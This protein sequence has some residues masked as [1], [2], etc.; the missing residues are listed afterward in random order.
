MYFRRQSVT[1]L[2][3]NYSALTNYS[4]GPTPLFSEVLLSEANARVHMLDTGHQKYIWFSRQTIRGY[5]FVESSIYLCMWLIY[6]GL[7]EVK[8][9]S[10]TKSKVKNS[11][12]DKMKARVAW[13]EILLI[14][15]WS[16]GTG[17]E[18]RNK[19]M[20]TLIREGWKGTGY[21]KFMFIL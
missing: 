9:K 1:F 10:T 2:T 7:R 18:A 5:F 6:K 4:F 20:L 12:H 21:V 17:T 19:E 8:V 16:N 11:K 13:R 3:L 15:G 14:D